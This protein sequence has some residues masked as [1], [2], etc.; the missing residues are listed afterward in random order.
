[1]LTEARDRRNAATD[2]I[3]CTKGQAQHCL[4]RMHSAHYPDFG[5]HRRGHQ[6]CGLAIRGNAQNTRGETQEVRRESIPGS[7]S[8]C[9]KC[10]AMSDRQ[11]RH[12]TKYM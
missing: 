7:Y 8:Y 1:M 11:K 5:A 6:T 3:S 9:Y 2:D 10:D 12:L 4:P